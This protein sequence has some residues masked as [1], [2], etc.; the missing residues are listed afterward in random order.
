M[1]DTVFIVIG[2]LAAAAL[3]AGNFLDAMRRT[4]KVDKPN[5]PPPGQ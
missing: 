2:V 4:K 3:M 5:D 1:W